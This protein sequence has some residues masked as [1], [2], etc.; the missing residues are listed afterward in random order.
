MYE[1]FYGLS[2]KPFQ[3]NPDP[4]FYFGSKQHRKAKSYLEYGLSHQEGFIVV[5]GEIG[6]GKTTLLQGLLAA[7]DT[8][9]ICVSQLVTT[10]LDPQETL[11]M[12]AA[13]FG[14][15]FEGCSKAE[16]L[17]ALEAFFLRKVRER[18]RCLLIVDEAQNLEARS[19]DEL[20]MLSNFQF[21]QVSLLQA[22]LVGQPELRA[23][24]RSP[25]MEQLRQRVTAACHIDLLDSGDT[26]AYIEHRLR[27]A[28]AGETP[29]FKNECFDLIFKS[30]CGVPRRINLLCDRLLL[31]G[32]LTGTREIAA[33]DVREVAQ[34]LGAETY[35]PAD[36][37]PFVA[38]STGKGEN[39]ES[40]PPWIGAQQYTE[41]ERLERSLLRLERL[42]MKTLS[43]LQKATA[44]SVNKAPAE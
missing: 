42:S 7:L 10:Q 29:I 15:K 26:R 41:L 33:D 34:E 38:Q 4:R 31:R 17:I 18:K 11:Q 6:A 40:V 39:A 23:T 20:R 22:F 16:V 2:A 5:T 1:A 44:A 14:L 43:L 25:R 30:T 27:C 13:G 35:G 24:L 21:N 19:L 28:G 9:R 32:F 3:I 37:A 8:N 12:V 36:E